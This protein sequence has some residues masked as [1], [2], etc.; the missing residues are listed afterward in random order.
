MGL[1]QPLNL[2]AEHIV[3]K[4]SVQAFAAEE[5]DFLLVQ[6]NLQATS[7]VHGA[8]NIVSSQISTL[9]TR[10]PSKQLDGN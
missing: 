9:V 8:D 10:S 5:N 7:V 4:Q 1:I 2:I 3:D 6:F